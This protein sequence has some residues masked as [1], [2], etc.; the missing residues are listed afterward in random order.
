VEDRVDRMA[1][2]G[3]RLILNYCDARTA[4][5][6]HE[7]HLAAFLGGGARAADIAAAPCIGDRSRLLLKCA[8]PNEGI[9]SR[10]TIRT[11]S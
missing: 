4:V 10:S 11:T 3:G 9:F 2:G 7:T 1:A 6:L 8:R 5:L